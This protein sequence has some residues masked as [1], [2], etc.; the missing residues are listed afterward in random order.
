VKQ[1][2][3]TDPPMRLG[4]GRKL[5]VQHLIASCLLLI[6]IICLI[7][8]HA[9]TEVIFEKNQEAARIARAKAVSLAK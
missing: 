7:N 9:N 2:Q 3:P 5:G 1:K 4:N 8:S 6:L